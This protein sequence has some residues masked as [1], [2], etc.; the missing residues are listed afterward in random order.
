MKTLTR[1]FF[2]ILSFQFVS[3]QCF[4]QTGYASVDRGEDCSEAE[5]AAKRPRSSQDSFVEKHAPLLQRGTSHHYAVATTDTAFKHMLSPTMGSEKNIVISFLNTFV[6]A[7]RG[8][9][10]TDVQEAPVAIPAIRR[11]GE[12]QT[13]MDLH[14]ISSN[15][16][17]YIIEMQAKRH[18]M[19]DERSLFYACSTYSR[20]L[21]EK[22]LSEEDWYI[23]L[24]PVIALQILDYDT[25][26]VKGIKS[27]VPDTLVSRV[28]RHP[29]PDGEFTK[30]YLITDIN[31]GQ[32]IDYLQ[33]VQVELPRAESRKLFFPPTESYTLVEWWLSLLK[34]ASDYTDDVIESFYGKKMM[35]ES[36]YRALKRLDLTTW[37]P[38]SVKEYQEDISRRD[39][40]GTVLSV[41]RE[42]G[43]KEGER[44]KAME[45]AK[46]M[47]GR[48]R[49]IPE[50]AEDTGLSEEEINSLKIHRVELSEA[51]KSTS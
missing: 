15:K 28:K 21:S 23:K 50:I 27:D 5:R 4:F 34:H 3:N 40:Y 26:R 49:P 20:Q 6:P 7:F 32:T 17:H 1:A 44:A 19:F 29:L 2:L 45:V 51:E 12:K 16:I 25:N 47:L 9:P 35:P 24:K 46:R 37:D 10:I 13:F 48:G 18:V 41:E 38:R 33:L 8:D 30:H 36:I 42:D 14:V 31:S 43:R 11:N 39:L 22:E